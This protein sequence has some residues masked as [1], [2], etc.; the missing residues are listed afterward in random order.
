MGQPQ[1]LK[2]ETLRFLWACGAKPTIWEIF[3]TLVMHESLVQ[4][5]PPSS[6]WSTDA[7]LLFLTFLGTYL[8]ELQNFV[9]SQSFLVGVL[10]TDSD[11]IT[12][13]I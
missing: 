3:R 12:Q 11:G 10:F 9:F 7:I 5:V 4:P 2:T 13:L 8:S 6:W 1:W